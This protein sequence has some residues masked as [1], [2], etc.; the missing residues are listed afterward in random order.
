[1][2]KSI[3]ISIYKLQ[4]ISKFYLY[5]I[6]INSVSNCDLIPIKETLFYLSKMRLI[7]LFFK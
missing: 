7:F 3:L 2:Y 1:M 6:I 4:N 5:E